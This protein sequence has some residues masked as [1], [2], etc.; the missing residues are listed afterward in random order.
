MCDLLEELDLTSVDII[1][2]IDEGIWVVDNEGI[3]IFVSE[4][5]ADMLGYT[6]DEMIG[7]PCYSFMD[8]GFAVKACKHFAERMEVISEKHKFRFTRKDGSTMHALVSGAPLTDNAG[9]IWGAIVAVTDTTERKEIREELKHLNSVLHAVQ[10]VNQLIVRERK[11]DDLLEKV[12]QLLTEVRVYH[13]AWIA[14]LDDELNLVDFYE[15]G[16]GSKFDELVER[17]DAGWLPRCIKRSLDEPGVHIIDDPSE[18]CEDCPLAKNYTNR[19][20]IFTAISYHGKTYGVLV[21]SS[22]KGLRPDEERSLIKAV[23]TDIAYALHLLEVEEEREEYYRRLRERNKELRTLYDL[24]NLATSHGFDFE[25]ICE[26]FVDLLPKGYQHPEVACARITFDDEVYMSEEFSESKWVQS[27]DIVVEGDSRGSIQVYYTEERPDFDEG[28]FLSQERELLEELAKQ[29]SD[30]YMHA[31]AEVELDFRFMLLNSATDS[32]FVH[33][34]DGK[35]IYVNEMA[36]EERGYSREELLD[37]NVH[38][39]DTPKYATLIKPRIEKLLEEG[40][41]MFEA[42]HQCKDGSTLPVEIHSRIIKRNE[43]S[44]ILTV[45]RDI[46]ERKEVEEALKESRDRFE[47]LFNNT[48]A[49]VYLLDDNGVFMEANEH[50]AERLGVSKEKITGK[51]LKD[52]FPDEQAEKFLEDTLEVF[53]TGEP[54]KEIIEPYDTPEGRGWATTDK[55][56]FSDESSENLV[57]GFSRDITRLKETEDRLEALHRYTSLLSSAEN[58]QEIAERTLDALESIFDYK[59]TEFAKAEDNILKLVETRGREEEP[60]RMEVPFEGKGLVAKAARTGSSIMVPDVREGEDYFRARKGIL[61]ELVVPAKI[62]G[63]I[64]AIINVEAEEPEA[65]T[66][67]DLQLVEMLATHVSS[68][69]AR[70]RRE[71]EL[72]E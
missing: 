42:A 16:L 12:C 34:L 13:N 5:M 50:L 72:E 65:F 62:E 71:E 41:A 69:I 52:L 48:P 24:S 61:S 58:M 25:A 9:N 46:T 40:S 21:I 18:T 32:I 66:D 7:A 10:T 56:P 20:S 4:T 68:A 33:D 31:R 1:N 63:E 44:L 36:Y 29:L 47:S 70:I 8:E 2:S 6:V 38:D 45:A 17:I 27:T 59:C 67:Q 54:K 30:L 43:E 49:M 26:D 51:R 19:S 11:S 39:L 37:M 64:V 60:V 35:I 55:I 15:A 22:Q 28:S 14:G 57:L 23:S 53:E 3:T